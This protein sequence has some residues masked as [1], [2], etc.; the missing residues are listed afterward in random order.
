MIEFELVTLFPEMFASV[1]AASLLGKAIDGGLVRVHLTDPRR[2]A[3]GKHRSV[4]D[5][6]YG[7]G[8]GMVMR[9]D[10]LVAAIEHVEAERGV[11]RKILLGP[12]GAPLDQNAVRRLAAL[13]RLLLVCCRYEGYDERVRAFVDEELSIG[14]FVLTGGEL[15]AMAII[16]ATARL[17]PGVL[18][19]ANSAVEESFQDGLLEHPHYTRPPEFRGARVPE[20]LTSG[21]H[22]RVRRW[23]RLEALRRTRDRRPDLLAKAPLTDE[24][25]ALLATEKP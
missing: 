19:N 13:P 10:P 1:L 9:P 18:G 22:E 4:D 15:P 5:A 24:D 20:I 8:S 2:F 23:R 11:A 21:D 17:I 16:D 6:P 12:A 25:R 14:D 3:P 7:G